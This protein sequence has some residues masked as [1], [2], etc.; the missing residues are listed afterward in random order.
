MQWTILRD[1]LPRPPH[2]GAHRRPEAG[3][4]RLP[5][6]RRARLP[7]GRGRRR[8]SCARCRPTT[9]ATRRCS[10][11]WPRSSAARR[12][13]TSGSGCC[14]SRPRTRAGW[15]TPSRAGA[16]AGACRATGLPVT[17]QRHRD[18]PDRP[19]TRSRATS[20]TEVV[21]T[22]RRRRAAAAARRRRRATGASPATSR[23][24]CAPTARPQLVQARAARGRRAGRAHRQDVS[25]FATPAAAEW[26]LLLEAL[27]QPH[28]TTRVRRLA[29]SCFVGLDAAGLDAA[30]RRLRRRPRAAAAGLGRGARGP[31][32]GR[33]VRGG[34]AR[35]SSCSRGSSA[36]SAASGCSPTCGTSRRSLHEAALEGQLGLTALLVWLRRRREEAAG[37]GGQERSRRLET[38][39][40]AVQVITVHT[41]K[42]LE[43]PVVLVPFAW[44]NWAGREP[45]TAVFHDDARPPGAR[46]RRP[47]QPRLGRARARSTSRRRPT[48]SCGSPTSR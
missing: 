33:A 27:E 39:A 6:R 20:P 43:F 26:Q 35:P 16:A 24:W 8:R 28:R 30:R 31:R 4:L 1:G 15:S 42:G 19:A 2:P 22:A 44:D 18:R 3:D 32:G 34:V 9:A 23:C 46:R 40:A 17:E 11:G 41:S 5:R 45:A 29:L 47:G 21:G 36:R 13:A 14:R 37:E 48:T 38:D 25:V 12:S 7:R 10:T